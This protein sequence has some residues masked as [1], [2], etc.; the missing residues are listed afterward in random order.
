M[1]IEKWL[2]YQFSS[3][4]YPGA[5]Y[6]TFQKEAIRELRK[7]VKPDFSATVY[8]NHYEFSAVLSLVDTGKLVYLD[9]GDVR[10]Y[11][12]PWYNRVLIR[13]MAH[14]KDWTGGPNHYCKWPEIK[15]TAL[16][17]IEEE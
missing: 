7:M 13:T 11:G 6:L 16:K 14:D 17:L 8:K 10:S 4:S 9:I 5:D 12:D 15:T 1:A 2:G 3:G